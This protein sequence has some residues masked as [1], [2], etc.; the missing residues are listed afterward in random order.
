MKAPDPDR[1]WLKRIKELFAYVSTWFNE[2]LIRVLAG[3]VA[4]VM[5]DLNISAVA[6]ATGLS[7]PTV[8]KG[9]HEIEVVKPRWYHDVTRIRKPGGGRKKVEEEDLFLVG[10]LDQLVN[11]Y[12]LGDPE[13]PLLYVSKSVR[14]LTSQLKV[15]GHYVSDWVVRRLLH[16]LSYSLQANRKT[17][18]GSDHPD[19]DAQFLYI[20]ERKAKQIAAG[21]PVISIDCKNKE[22]IGRFKNNGR[23]WRPEGDPECVNT[24][25]F[26]DKELGKGCPYGVYDVV[27]NKAFVNLGV[28]HDTATF[29]VESIRG[30]W[31]SMGRFDYP[32][33]T[34]LLIL[35]DAGGSNSYRTH[36]WKQELMKLADELGLVIMVSHYPPGTS[37]WNLIEHKV[38]SPISIN[39]RGQPLMSLDLMADLIRSTTNATGLKI[40]CVIDLCEYPKGRRLSKEEIDEYRQVLLEEN[41]HGKW[42]YSILHS[43]GWQ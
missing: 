7:R 28:S 35:A 30:W 39:W 36:L 32:D 4:M 9:R 5:E 8:R 25:D 38:F 2:R 37:K 31:Y 14:H 34:S 1:G 20:A 26:K 43:S 3:A 23:T 12:T 33:A 27:L 21:Q 22:L 16:G 10:N 40:E 11:P 41:F 17:L 15:M 13:S 29:S 6:R 42:N 18:E 19:R 24:H